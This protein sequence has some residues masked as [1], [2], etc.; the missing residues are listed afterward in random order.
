MKKNCNFFNFSWLIWVI[1]LIWP[2]WVQAS[3]LDSIG[4]KLSSELFGESGQLLSPTEAFKVQVTPKNAQTLVARFNVAK[5][6][7]LYKRR[8]SFIIE[9][10]PN[11]TIRAIHWPTA[12]VHSDPY[13][14]TQPVFYKPFQVTIDLTRASGQTPPVSLIV[15]YQG[16]SLKGVCYPPQHQSFLLD[17]PTLPIAE[18]SPIHPGSTLLGWGARL[19]S[20]HYVGE[21]IRLSSTGL[22]I[23][24]FFGF[25][26]L[27]AF[28]PCMLPMF[29]IL[30]SILVGKGRSITWLRGFYL[31]AIYVMGMAITYTAAGIAAAL[32]GT[33]LSNTLQ[34]PW[35][36]GTFALLFVLLALSMFGLYEL[37]MPS[38]LQSQLIQTSN[39]F[40]TKSFL[41]LF[42]MGAFSAIIIGPCLAA[43]LAGALLFMGQTH[44]L[45]LGGAALFS[46]ALGMGLPLLLL[47][48]SA[49]F[50][51][52]R[53]GPWMTIVKKIFGWI[54]LATA[55]WMI[56]PILSGHE[57]ILLIALLITSCAL[58]LLIFPSIVTSTLAKRFG[59]AIGIFLLMLGTVYLIGFST[60][61]D[62]ILHPL[63]TLYTASPSN[64]ALSSLQFAPVYNV[65]DLDRQIQGASGHYVMLDF[66]ADWCVSCQELKHLTFRDPK[67]KKR[68]KDVVLL[69]AD[70]TTNTAAVQLLLKKFNL[71]GPPAIIFF[72]KSGHE[73]PGTR[74]IGYQDARTFLHTLN[75]VLQ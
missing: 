12:A 68:L 43:P 24:S 27:L 60:G 14:G 45:W 58:W 15:S 18:S 38:R 23:A 40:N 52:P 11:I 29:P 3:G 64:E 42:S 28:T 35:V 56:A 41:G 16:C 62:N 30:S 7:Y 33:L 25:G 51:L 53:I 4:Q 9:E 21:L 47:G 10:A 74:V 46:F 26:L 2:V 6:Y 13:F 67:V 50:L 75:K 57:L 44:N 69:Q 66:Y 17:L 20:T 39:R 70:V 1:F 65:V 71:F 61:S 55:L 63:K 72:G 49:G 19:S 8:T 37:Q 48:S 32:T 22:V 34:N 59:K 5:G 54:L 73:L 31:S 36:L